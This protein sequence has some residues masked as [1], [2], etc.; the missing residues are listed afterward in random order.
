MPV[1]AFF[2]LRF[3]REAKTSM[4]AHEPP[5]APALARRLLWKERNVPMLL[6]AGREIGR[7]L[8]LGARTRQCRKGHNPSRCGIRALDPPF[9][10]RRAECLVF[11]AAV[12]S[13]ELNRP[14]IYR[15]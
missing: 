10:S 5:Q 4:Q 2:V 1:P 15:G 12:S 11:L 3:L 14:R 7:P 6:W 8:T 13:S 9:R